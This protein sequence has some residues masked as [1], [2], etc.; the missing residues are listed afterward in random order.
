[1]RLTMPV[2]KFASNEQER[3]DA[4]DVGGGILA[5]YFLIFISPVLLPTWL[6]YVRPEFGDE[7]FSQALRMVSDSGVVG[8]PPRRSGPS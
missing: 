1:M 6:L 3:S 8:L 7:G 4:A 2:M 5:I